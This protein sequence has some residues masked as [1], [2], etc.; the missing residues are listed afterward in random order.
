MRATLTRL[1]SLAKPGLPVDTKDKMTVW[2]SRPWKESAVTTYT[3][4]LSALNRIVRLI[5]SFLA[6]SARSDSVEHEEGTPDELD[7][8]LDLVG[9]RFRFSVLDLFVL[10]IQPFATFLN[11]NG[12]CRMAIEPPIVGGSS[13]RSWRTAG[14]GRPRR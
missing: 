1:L 11:G 9:V 14:H 13:G 6:R 8:G 4:R 10:D 5:T 12:L 3:L 7:N 2:D